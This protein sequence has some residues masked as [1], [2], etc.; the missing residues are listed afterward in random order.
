MARFGAV[1]EGSLSDLS[2]VNSSFSIVKDYFFLMVYRGT[3]RAEGIVATS[4]VT[5]KQTREERL[6]G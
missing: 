3:R 4:Q 2:F 5:A 1:G 6:Y